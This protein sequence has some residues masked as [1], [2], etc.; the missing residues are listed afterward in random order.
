MKHITVTVF[1]FSHTL[2]R[3]VET[4]LW[5][6]LQAIQQHYCRNV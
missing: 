3:H 6:T 5:W 2:Y 1:K 4:I